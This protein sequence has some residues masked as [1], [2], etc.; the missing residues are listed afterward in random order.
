MW[1]SPRQ[2]WMVMEELG[3]HASAHSDMPIGGRHRLSARTS[4]K[5]HRWHYTP[6][7]YAG[8]EDQ[9]KSLWWECC[10]CVEGAEHWRATGRNDGKWGRAMGVWGQGSEVHSSKNQ[11]SAKEPQVLVHVTYGG[12]CISVFHW[13][14]CILKCLRSI[15]A[16]NVSFWILVAFR[17]QCWRWCS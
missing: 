14:L 13:D 2:I 12:V 3:L 7:P 9:H 4:T 17:Q 11:G 15:V 16:E 1:F 5:I 6:V 10:V 8:K